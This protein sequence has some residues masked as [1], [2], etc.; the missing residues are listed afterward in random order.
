MVVSGTTD[1]KTAEDL[2]AAKYADLGPLQGTSGA[3]IYDL[4][5]FTAAD[6]KSIVIFSNPFQVIFG[7]AALQ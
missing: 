4:G 7:E 1:A 2:H 6:V 5:P 3:Q